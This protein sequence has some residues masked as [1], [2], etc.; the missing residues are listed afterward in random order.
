MKASL[1]LNMSQSLTLTPQ[2]QQAIRLLQLSALDLT[3]EIQ[4]AIESNPML[5]L[6]ES[7]NN[8]EV[9]KNTDSHNKEQTAD[10][11]QA[12][13]TEDVIPKELPVDTVW[14]DIY[15]STFS[16]SQT[17]EDSPSFENFYTSDINLHDHLTWQMQLTPLSEIDKEIA[18]AIIDA[19]SEDGF[20]TISV[21]DIQQSLSKNEQDELPEF[22][23][24]EAVLHRIQRFDPV[25]VAA[26]DLKE[27]LLLQLEQLPQNE[28]DVARAKL[29]ITKHIELLGQHNYTQLMRRSKL[30]QQQL[31]SAMKLIQTLHPRPGTLIA[32][33][34]TEYVIPDVVVKKQDGRWCVELNPE[35]L[36][37]VRI[38]NSYAP[39]VQRA[40]KSPD[41][42]FMRNNLQEARWFIK[43]LQSRH[44][45][46][47]KV[48]TRIVEYQQDFLE[49]GE[50]AMKP[51][52]L[53]DI[54]QDLDMHESTISRVTTQK[55]MHTPLGVFELKY[56][57][58]SHVSTD[59]GGECSSTAIRA[60]IKKL[61]A[62]E[63]QQKPLSDNKIAQVLSEQGI[64]VARRTIAK[65]RES[66]SIPPSNERKSLIS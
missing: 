10:Q 41:N 31:Q 3:Q 65:Y 19:V 63:N 45:T 57:F 30:N 4:Q 59:S 29:I 37:K 56:F 38:N 5:E 53:H 64:K 39:L 15:P 36:P 66:M 58:S 61:I 16:R 35:S 25:G 50:E 47:L 49:Y 54:A 62:A 23:E 13:Q 9:N 12:N 33:S 28:A 2:L 17:S 6:D 7:H 1:Q 20:L 44:D 52:V 24:I 42:T 46:L 40:N 48:A 8:Q 51:L 21:E 43:S 27:C 34:K 60:V 55:F 22:D 32:P 14:D 26:R 11:V 18:E